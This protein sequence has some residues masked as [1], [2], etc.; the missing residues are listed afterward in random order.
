M[1]WAEN[2]GLTDFH[3][4]VNRKYYSLR[5]KQ[6][7]RRPENAKCAWLNNEKEMC[8]NFMPSFNFYFHPPRFLPIGVHNMEIT[9]IEMVWSEWSGR[10]DERET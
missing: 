7:Q 10:V 2:D 4:S 8:I 6:T 1:H 5:L 3:L 9:I